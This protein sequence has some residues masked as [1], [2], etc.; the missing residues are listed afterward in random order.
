M[1]FNLKIVK[2]CTYANEG[3]SNLSKYQ[4]Q[5][6]VFSFLYSKLYAFGCF[7]FQLNKG[8]LVEEDNYIYMPNC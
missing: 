5:S 8:S 4:N 6:K 3:D 2:K 1:L 7:V